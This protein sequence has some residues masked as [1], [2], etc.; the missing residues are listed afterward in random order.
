MVVSNAGKSITPVRVGAASNVS[1]VGGSKDGTVLY[2]A[3]PGGILVS[4]DSGATWRDVTPPDGIIGSTLRAFTSS[5]SGTASAEVV[6]VPEPTSL[7]LL[8]IGLIAV[9]L[10]RP[11][12]RTNQSTR[13]VHAT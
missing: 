1:F 2:A 5:V 13:S 6:P 8:G 11:T 10:A 7:V 4:G 3:T 12:A 9:G